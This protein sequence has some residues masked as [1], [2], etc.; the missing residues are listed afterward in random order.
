MAKSPTFLPSRKFMNSWVVETLAKL[1]SLPQDISRNKSS[2]IYCLNSRTRCLKKITTKKKFQMMSFPSRSQTGTV[3][4]TA[5]LGSGR[6]WSLRLYTSSEGRM[7]LCWRRRHQSARNQFRR[8]TVSYLLLLALENRAL[9]FFCFIFWSYH[10]HFN[11]RRRP[12]W[13]WAL[14]WFHFLEH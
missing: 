4:A 9:T 5:R 14:C 2:L 10:F 12:E 7:N 3:T 1:A 11:K 13:F 8:L 6:H